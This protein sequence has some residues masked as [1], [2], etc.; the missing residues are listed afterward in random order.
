MLFLRSNLKIVVGLC[1]ALAISLF[2]GS[3]STLLAQTNGRDS[4]LAPGEQILVLKNGEMLSGHIEQD[5]GHL[6]VQVPQGSRLVIAKTKAEFVCNSKSEA[7]WGKSARIRASDVEQQVNL[8]RWC[9]KH[10]L[11]E[12]A[13]SQ[14]NIVMNCDVAPAEL[15]SLNRQL[16]VMRAS[17]ARR[18]QRELARSLKVDEATGDQSS[19]IAQHAKRL[20]PVVEGEL[21]AGSMQDSMVQ[22]ASFAAPVK[23]SDGSSSSTP[24]STNST[25]KPSGLAKVAAI[26]D[27]KRSHRLNSVAPTAVDPYDASGFNAQ[28]QRR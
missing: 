3:S 2:L 16:V 1:A 20:A 5:A 27:L 26:P 9:L 14:L 24:S 25:A 22:Q 18:Q 13:E 4:E 21:V 7:F 12:H 15:E 11:F 28:T 8:Y 6:I 23:P 19:T 10:K 17:E